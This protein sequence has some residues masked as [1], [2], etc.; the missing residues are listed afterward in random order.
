[1]DIDNNPNILC[2]EIESRLCAVN[3]TCGCGCAFEAE[4]YIQ[5]VLVEQGCE[6]VVA[7]ND[8]RCEEELIQL[9]KCDTATGSNCNSCVR[10]SVNALFKTENTTSCLDFQSTVCTSSDTCGCGQCADELELWYSCAYAQD[11]PDFS[12][13]TPASSP[14]SSPVAAPVDGAPT[15]APT[16]G[17]ICYVCG[18]ENK[19]VTD[20]LM[21]SYEGEMFPCEKLEQLA[22]G[23]TFSEIACLGARAFA[24]DCG[25][26]N[27]TSPTNP[28]VAPPVDSTLSPSYSSPCFVCGDAD[29]SVDPSKTVEIGNE[30]RPCVDVQVEYET[31]QQVSPF[32]CRILFEEVTKSCNCGANPAPTILVPPVSSP[33]ANSSIAPENGESKASD[34]DFKPVYLSAL[35]AI[36]PL[37]FFIVYFVKR[38]KKDEAVGAKPVL[39]RAV[40][41]ENEINER[42]P[43]SPSPGCHP[44]GKPDS[45]HLQTD[46]SATSSI[47]TDEEYI[48]GR[49]P[50]AAA[51]AASQNPGEGW[52]A[53][54]SVRS[55]DD[56]HHESV[57]EV[58]A[59]SGRSSD[60]SGAC[61]NVDSTSN[62]STVASLKSSGGNLPHYKDQC[63]VFAE[64]AEPVAVVVDEVDAT[65]QAELHERKRPADPSGIRDV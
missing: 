21:F 64:G 34:K 6:N 37:V 11:C 1:M 15:P 14:L 55:H 47:R 35:V 61:A 62:A 49:L 22:L 10:D 59:G 56:R 3:N 42:S 5:C 19:E 30:V 43:G 60:P 50:V 39:M 48:Y 4:I 32:E 2:G 12:C 27:V 23:Q 52:S 40:A 18:D 45:R 13:P 31:S 24:L 16:L 36:V 53:S 51:V 17:V 38:E 41:S 7:C 54:D 57:G 20:G 44:A 46:A 9:S 8:T 33:T 65:S 63:R 58:S 25:C 26:V 28:P 29:L